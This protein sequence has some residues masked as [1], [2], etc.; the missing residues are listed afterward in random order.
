MTASLRE[1]AEINEDYIT[2][3]TTTQQQLEG[4]VASLT[5]RLDQA[6]KAAAE[7][8]RQDVDVQAATRRLRAQVPL[9]VL[10]LCTCLLHQH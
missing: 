1:A 5:A 2:E 9:A 10:L 6:T 4:E 3:L 8:E 7:R